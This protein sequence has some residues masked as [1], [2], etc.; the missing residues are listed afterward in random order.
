MARARVLV[1]EDDADLR[2]ELVDYL[3]F[4]GMDVDGAANIGMMTSLLDS[5]FWDVLV[6]D[7]GLPDGDGVAV[8]RRVRERLGLKLGIVM[9]TARGHVEDRIA[10]FSVGADAYLVKPVNPRELKAVIDQ[11]WGRLKNGRDKPAELG[12]RL[13]ATTL[14][15]CI[16]GGT[17]I[18]LTGSE[19]RLLANLF[20]TPGEVVSRDELCKGLPPGGAAD[21]T[22]RLDTL[23]SRLRTKVELVSGVE[24]PIKTFRNLGYAFTGLIEE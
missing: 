9:V 7:L 16:P 21:E 12:W 23:V 22:R 8:A 1:V 15:L 17:A 19:A 3:R 18:T 24:L 14:Q 10:G 2:V 6:L 20:N 13:D 5:S 4:Y 11:L